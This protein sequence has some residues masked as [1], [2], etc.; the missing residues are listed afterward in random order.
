MKN[1][2]E[3]VDYVINFAAETHVDRSIGTWE[4]KQTT[5]ERW[6]QSG[7]NSFIKTN[8][9]GTQSLLEAVKSSKIK[10]FIQISTDEVYGP[11]EKPS[12]ETDPFNPRN[13]YAA[14]KAAA[15][16]LAI[17]YFHTFKI[18]ICITRSCNNYGPWQGSEK[19]IPVTILSALANTPIP[20]YG[21]GKNI[22]DW[23]FV[24]DNTAAILAILEKGTPGKFYN[25]PGEN[26]RTNI[27]LAKL[28]LKLMGK[29]EKLIR[30]VKDRP[31][32]DLKYAMDGAKLHS[33]CGWKPKYTLEQGLK[34]AIDFYK[35]HEKE[36]RKDQKRSGVLERIKGLLRE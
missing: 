32:H 17:A 28:I 2:I 14:T 24:E 23:I 15:E 4:S 12:K 6:K 9:L 31:G 3:D 19:F 5:E 18:P 21:T 35:E 30:F 36:F 20:I 11:V 1:L 25:I 26:L 10:K 22:R 7:E 27:E 16:C 34:I 8:I 13:P 29:S 33:E